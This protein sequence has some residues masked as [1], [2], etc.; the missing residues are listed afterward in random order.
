LGAGPT[1]LLN[2]DDLAEG[3][4]LIRLEAK[5]S[6]GQSSFGDPT[7]GVVSTENAPAA[8]DTVR[9]AILY[10]P[11]TLPAA[12]VVAPDLVFSTSA[13]STAEL[14]NTL[15]VSNLGDGDLGWTASSDAANVTLSSNSG[16]TPATVVVTVDPTGLAQGLQQ[17]TLTF[18][19]TETTLAPVTVAYFINVENAAQNNRYAVES[20]V[21]GDESP[22]ED[23]GVWIIGGR[24]AQQVVALDIASSDGGATLTGTMTY[25]GEG[26]I[27]VRATKT[28][29]QVYQIETQWGDAGAPWNPEG[30]WRLGSREEVSLVALQFSAADEGTTLEGVMSY[31]D[32]SFYGFRATLQTAPTTADRFPLLPGQTIVRE[33]KL[34]AESGD[35]YLIFQTDGN[36]VVYTADDQYVWGLQSITDQYAQAQSV[37][38]EPDGNFV[39]RGADD[40]MIWSALREQP[41]Q[42]T[43]LTLTADG[44]LQLVAGDSGAVL[45]ASNGVTAQP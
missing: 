1:L 6:L 11:L 21:G 5:D 8:H 35:H 44:V 15:T 28:E 25:A 45:W 19:P 24:Q 20:N 22:W 27:A 29:Q 23:A 30:T 16:N 40:E 14:T 18:T 36:V 3:P 12:L 37:Q 33:Q 42:A 32:G 26:P 31:A 4:H 41:D 39:V 43:Y 9:F 13:G 10:D 34:P 7:M 17:G 38:M 2:A